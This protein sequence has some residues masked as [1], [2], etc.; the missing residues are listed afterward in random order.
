MQ[1]EKNKH[2][3]ASPST[4]ENK[5]A[6]SEHVKEAHQQADAD[7]EKDPDFMPGNEADDL[8]EEESVKLND[9]ENDLV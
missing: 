4:K 7:I 8:D 2:R 5:P 9:D 3:Q 6:D 1:P